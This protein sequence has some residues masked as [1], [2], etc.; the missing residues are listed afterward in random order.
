MPSFRSMTMV[1]AGTNS[2]ML[3]IMAQLLDAQLSIDQLLAAE[4]VHYNCY[5]CVM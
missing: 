2:R 4:V 5:S 3:V 1:V